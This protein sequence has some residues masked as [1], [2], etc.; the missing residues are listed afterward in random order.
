MITKQMVD[1][2]IKY[3]II[4]I[5]DKLGI[6][7]CRIGNYWFYFAGHEGDA[8]L[9]ALNYILGKSREEIVDEIYNVL[10][11]FM[12]PES[13]EL[14]DEYKY[15]DWYLNERLELAIKTALLVKDERSV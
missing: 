8:C 13:I 5:E 10:D 1:D 7:V 3:G 14:H 2:G 9:S 12:Q 15:Y 11:D 6:P 4:R